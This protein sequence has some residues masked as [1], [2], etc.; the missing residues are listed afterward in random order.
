MKAMTL[1][2]AM[3]RRLYD[4]VDTGQAAPGDNGGD[5]GRAGD[6]ARFRRAMAEFEDR[7]RTPPIELSDEE[8]KVAFGEETAS[9][10]SLKVSTIATVK[11]SF[12]SGAARS[13]ERVEGAVTDETKFKGFGGTL[14]ASMT[15]STT[16]GK[17]DSSSVGI[18]LDFS[19]G[20]V[21]G[22][23]S[24]TEQ[25]TPDVAEELAGD[26]AAKVLDRNLLR[27]LTGG[28]GGQ[29]QVVADWKRAVAA[30][31]MKASGRLEISI[32]PTQGVWRLQ[33]VAA[34][35]RSTTGLQLGGSIPVGPTSVAVSAGVHQTKKRVEAVYYNPNTL[36]QLTNLHR[37]RL[38][39]G[40]TSTAGW[41]AMRKES[42]QLRNVV[43]ALA[44]TADGARTANGH[45]LAAVLAKV[46]DGS[47]V[48]SD[49]ASWKLNNP[50]NANELVPWLMALKSGSP[51]QAKAADNFIDGY[52]ANAAKL[53]RS[54]NA[55]TRAEA[56]DRM[57]QLFNGVVGAKR[58]IEDEAGAKSFFK[59]R[60]LS[61]AEVNRTVADK[62]ADKY[63][64]LELRVH[65]KL[66]PNADDDALVTDW[67]GGPRA[68][69][70]D[71]RKRLAAARQA[72]PDDADL[73]ELDIQAR[74]LRYAVESTDDLT[75]FNST[76]GKEAALARL[77]DTVDTVFTEPK[78]YMEDENL[79]GVV[80]RRRDGTPIIT[81]DGRLKV[82]PHVA[83]DKA[84]LLTDDSIKASLR[85]ATAKDPDGGLDIRPHVEIDLG[86]E[87]KRYWKASDADE[88]RRNAYIADRRT[89]GRYLTKRRAE[90]DVKERSGLSEAFEKLVDHEAE[91]R[92]RT[93]L[94]QR[95]R[96]RREAAREDDD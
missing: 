16:P 24:R 20:A 50:S 44:D 79:Y 91:K 93:R 48:E 6:D 39:A 10:G 3:L 53:K 33:S 62:L 61:R 54:A 45:D 87:K 8:R 88:R 15:Y 52:R 31:L 63:F 40:A 89:E 25:I 47:L 4:S 38:P 5:G 74:S 70:T 17:P 73:I 28:E 82:R 18:V 84:A 11:G 23:G 49:A 41:D 64:D 76:K 22:S 65:E 60:N 67:V 66:H 86:T 59:Q 69:L 85:R 75:R 51:E 37:M 72:N 21:K 83:A 81:G 68:S 92:R 55:D 9:D 36:G 29:E 90:Q 7:L 2:Y 1:Q 27:K 14:A 80:Q 57:E 94:L 95:I 30:S 78:I 96:R 77:A 43:E 58:A 46:K 12:G 56:L 42:K 26:L 71:L 34:V 13:G 35:E 32:A 19:T